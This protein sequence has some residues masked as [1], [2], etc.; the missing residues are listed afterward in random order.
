MSFR[1]AAVRPS[2]ESVGAE[3]ARRIRLADGPSP[4]GI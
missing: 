4:W 2:W 1:S 3:K